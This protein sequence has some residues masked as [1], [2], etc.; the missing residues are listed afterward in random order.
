MMSYNTVNVTPFSKINNLHK[1]K[2]KLNSLHVRTR[3]WS[4]KSELEDAG[5][6]R[7]GKD[8]QTGCVDRT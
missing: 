2:T 4:E 8:Q 6:H 7:T 1:S 5:G 3:P